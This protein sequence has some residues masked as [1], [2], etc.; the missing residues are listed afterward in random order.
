GSYVGDEHRDEEGRDFPY[1][2]FPVDVVLLFEA[3]EPANAA[4]D[5]DAD[6]IW[7][8]TV[9]LNE[10][11]VGHRLPG[12]RD[13][14]LCILIRALRFLSI[15]EVERIEPLHLGGESNGKFRCV[16]FGDRRGSRLPF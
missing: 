4:A 12:R 2:A 11:G 5:Y 10:A 15:H 3:L 7:V 16:K 13:G 1:T 6:A 8:H 14:V 9:P